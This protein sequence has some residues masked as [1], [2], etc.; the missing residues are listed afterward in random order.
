MKK[1]MK[2]LALALALCMALSVSAFAADFPTAP[3]VDKTAHTVNFKITN[4][5]S[6][7]QVALLVLRK[8]TELS[9]ASESNILYI[10]QVTANSSN[11]AEFTATIAA[12]TTTVNN[13][14]VDVYVGSSSISGSGT[15]WDDYKNIEV[16]NTSS[17]TIAGNAI[18]KNVG[19]KGTVD[20]AEVTITRPG[21][22]IG[23]NV[24]NVALTQ[25]IWALED[26]NNERK[27]TKAIDIDTSAIE[28]GEVWFSAVFSSTKLD[29]FNIEKV[30]ALFRDASKEVH[31]IGELNETDV[32]GDA[33][34]ATN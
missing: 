8:G 28:E 14:Y 30:G 12:S 19:D 2:A 32:M 29:G 24:K 27:Y 20:G 11:E 1:F 17:I 6:G 18:K 25:M 7:E 9:A 16:A 10:D 33:A 31:Y 21:A 22:A 3:T 26:E 23:I 15:A 5:P 34:P 13:D 4:V